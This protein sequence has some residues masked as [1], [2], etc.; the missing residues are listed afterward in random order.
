M[1]IPE[2]CDHWKNA[3]ENGNPDAQQTLK[4]VLAEKCLEAEAEKLFFQRIAGAGT[5]SSGDDARRISSNAVQRNPEDHSGDILCRGPEVPANRFKRM[6]RVITARSCW[7]LS[8][9]YARQSGITLDD[10]ENADQEAVRDFVEGYDSEGGHIGKPGGIAWV[11]ESTIPT[12][13]ALTLARKLG[14]PH[15]VNAVRR[16][17]VMI[18]IGYTKDEVPET[19]HVP[20]VTDGIDHPP[21]RP[22]NDCSATN[23]TTHPLEASSS[24]EGLPEAVHRSCKVSRIQIS[25][26]E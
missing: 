4:N 19:V 9:K 16:Q 3:L 14:L 24:E 17:G 6:V 22:V 26:L 12:S 11:T 25:C 7:F 8:E 2:T 1:K 21:F 18:K 10:L 15:V 5:P 20:R 13:D 23:G